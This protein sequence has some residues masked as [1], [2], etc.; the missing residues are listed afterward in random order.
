MQGGKKKE[1]AEGHRHCGLAEGPKKSKSYRTNSGR[2]KGQ[3]EA[4]EHVIL[5]LGWEEWREGYGKVVWGG[6]EKEPWHR[7]QGVS[8]CGPAVSLRR[9]MTKEGIEGRPTTGR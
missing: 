3:Q 7:T 9:G 5:N 2:L 1:R 4:V 8:V 6:Q